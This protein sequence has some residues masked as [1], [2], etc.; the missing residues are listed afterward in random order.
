MVE[1]PYV[2]NIGLEFVQQASEGRV[3]RRV[4]VPVPGPGRVD[5]VE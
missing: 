1:V 3:H 5:Q 2:D 4:T